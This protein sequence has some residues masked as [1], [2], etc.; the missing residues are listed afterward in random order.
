[1]LSIVQANARIAVQTDTVIV[2]PENVCAILDF[3][4]RIVLLTL[5][6]LLDASTVIASL[7]ILDKVY[8]LPINHAFASLVGMATDVI[9]RCRHFQVQNQC[10]RAL[11]DVIFSRIVILAVESLGLFKHQIQKLAVL[12]AMQIPTV[13]HGSCLLFA[14]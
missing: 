8:L 3:L 4:V 2:R 9:Q 5:V 1:M 6:L 14:F 13:M 10:L 11:T 7:N 12:R